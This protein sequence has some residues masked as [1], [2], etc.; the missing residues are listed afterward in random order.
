M[1][2]SKHAET[3]SFGQTFKQ[4][5][6]ASLYSQ[7]YL[8][9]RAGVSPTY[10]SRLESDA[11]LPSDR[12]LDVMTAY[13][14]SVDR[15]EWYR[16][17]GRLAPELRDLLYQPGMVAFVRSTAFLTEDQVLDLAA[18]IDRGEFK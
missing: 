14:P 11:F 1:N 7:R 17:A 18:R 13:L 10:L 2:A 5:R 3:R 8:A 9:L 16:L 6:K 12:V 15:D 4:A